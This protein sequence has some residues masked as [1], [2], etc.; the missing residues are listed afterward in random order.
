MSSALQ[1]LLSQREAS[2]KPVVVGLVGAGQMGIDLIVQ[3]RLMQGIRLGAVAVRSRLG[4]AFEAMAF[5]GYEAAHVAEVSRASEVDQAVESGRVALTVD[6]AALMGAGRIDVVIDA[7]GHPES[8]AIVASAAIEAGKHIVMLNVEADVTIG[9]YLHDQ[10][11]RAGVIYTGAAGDEPAA[12]A[13]LVS[14]ART[15]GLTVIA[16][17]KGKNNA[18]DHAAVPRDFVA[19]ARA[20]NMNPRVL[21]EFVDGSKTMVEMTALANATGLVPDRPGMHGPDA[22]KDALSEVFRLAADGGLL[23]RT[24]VVDFTV[25]KGVAPGVFC[26]VEPA[27]PRVLERLSDLHVGK[28]PLFTLHR[29]Y[30]LTSIETPLT[31]ARAVL[32]GEADLVPLDE[33]VAEACAIAKRDLEPGVVLGRIGEE[34]YRGW[35][36]SWVEASRLGALPL[37]LAERSTVKRA[38]RRGELLTYENCAADE[39][40]TI[41]R[42]RKRQDECDAA[43]H[44]TPA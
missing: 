1:R 43:I 44:G 42:L 18:F 41:T 9:R 12:A 2:G 10:A 21:V 31:A 3:L 38:I 39:S 36:M 24:G 8:G 15:L 7:T 11:R 30:H 4:A 5:A 13:E 14:F 35:T 6:L 17:G 37:G 25:G 26:V 23:S 20:R 28:G 33:P 29:P 22:T 32:L 34:D 27:H 16:A 19:E 40:L